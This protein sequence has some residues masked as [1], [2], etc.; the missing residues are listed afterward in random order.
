MKVTNW[1]EEE[2]YAS[3]LYL[4]SKFGVA[5]DLLDGDP[6]NIGP[7]ITIETDEGVPLTFKLEDHF[8]WDNWEFETHYFK[9]VMSTFHFD[10]AKYAME[11]L[12]VPNKKTRGGKKGSEQMAN[13]QLKRDWAT[14]LFELKIIIEPEEEASDKDYV[15]L[16]KPGI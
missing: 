9:L 4:S 10:Q 6:I 13:P 5:P 11:D 7:K 15:G 1:S 14:Q 3:L 16:E 2:Y 8:K 12:P